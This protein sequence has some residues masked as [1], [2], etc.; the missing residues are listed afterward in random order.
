MFFVLS[1]G[2]YGLARVTLGFYAGFMIGCCEIVEYIIYT[3][4]T[5]LSLGSLIT[6]TTKISQKYDPL[7]WLAF[8]V[9]AV[10]IYCVGG[11]VFWRVNY[12]LAFLSII[13]LLIYC[14]GSLKFVDIRNTHY[15]AYTLRDP[16]IDDTV[17][18]TQNV[19]MDNMQPALYIGGIISFMR[20]MPLS[21][22][23]YVGIESLSFAANDISYVS[24]R[25][26]KLTHIHLRQY[27][28]F[29]SS[30]R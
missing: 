18:G 19:L 10:G 2:G 20:V 1:G 25:N 28:I 12:I 8:Y 22:W 27:L 4:D 9:S 3:A 13:I 26:K 23:F 6:K 16:I 15:V 29:F 30:P 24:N 14:F 21:G 7:I 17:Y 5:C 11:K